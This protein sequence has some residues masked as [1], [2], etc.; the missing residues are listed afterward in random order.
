MTRAF[1]K[2]LFLQTGFY[3]VLVLVLAFESGCGTMRRV[4][5]RNIAG[6]FSGPSGSNV[7]VEDNDPELV[8]DTLPFVLKTYEALLAADPLN[9]ELY[10]NAADG[11]VK[12][13]NLFVHEEAE[14]LKEVDFKQAQYLQ[15]RAT[16]LYLRGRDYALTGLALRHEAFDRRLKRNPS[17]ILPRL[18]PEDVPLLFWAAAGWAGAVSTDV[19]NMSL[20]AELPIVEAMMRRALEL[21]GDFEDGLIHEFFITY[22]GSRSKAMGGSA[23]RAMEH[24]QSA[25]NLTGGKKASPFVALASSVA[26]RQQDY[27]MFED[28]LNRALAIDA[29]S[30]PRWCLSNTLAREKARWL[31]DRRASLFLEIEE[32]K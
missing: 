21:D 8:R 3:I 18:S 28:L 24:F 4:A 17:E 20:V 2:D 12:Y 5:V 16:K 9:R 29:D 27:K 14:R 19:D 1:V 15:K 10:L 7:F 6:L 32:N 26:V 31:M 25:V 23:E 30:V 22:E 13:A 11:F